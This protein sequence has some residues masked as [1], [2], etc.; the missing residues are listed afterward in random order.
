MPSDRQS[1]RI[2][3]AIG[4]GD[5]VQSFQSWRS[6][7]RPAGETSKTFSSECFDF[8]NQAGVA[9]K[10]VSYAE[11][12]G[13]DRSEL[14]E[15]ENLPKSKRVPAFGVWFHLRQATYAWKLYQICRRF[16]ATTAIIDSGTTHWFFLWPL[17][18]SGI[19]VIPN[20]HNV[21]HPVTNPP[22]G[23]RKL[24]SRLDGWFFGVGSRRAIGVS[25]ECGRQYRALAR[26]NKEFTTYFAQFFAEDFLRIERP[27]SP[28]FNQVFRL[29][30]VGRVEENKGAFDLLEVARQLKEKGSRPFRIDICGDGGALAELRARVANM[31]LEE[32]V[33]VHGRLVRENLLPFYAAAHV[34]LVPT[35]STFTEGLPL[36]CVEAALA[37]R[38]VITSCLSN[39]LEIFEDAI[40]EAL[41]EDIQS[42]VRCIESL[43]K[44]PI[45]YSRRVAATEK[46]AQPFLDSSLGLRAVLQ[47]LL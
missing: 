32:F 44:D 36:V 39:A 22:R 42:Y 47:S 1:L 8:C 3:F 6:G 18:L 37:G 7:T 13:Y 5:V 31:K 15:V 30:F 45:E 20:F 12:S 46:A 2:V 28:A 38:P 33:C 29:L 34:V 24:L 19:E 10:F 27:R 16:G 35:R 43:S 14:V 21:Y 26:K 41:P 4:P 17:H 9:A 40:S 23:Y 25:H 11:R